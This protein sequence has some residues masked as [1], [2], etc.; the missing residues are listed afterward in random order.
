MRER[1]S[2]PDLDVY[3]DPA[4][5]HK[6]HRSFIQRWT[7]TRT[8][9]L[10][11]CQVLVVHPYTSRRAA[12]MFPVVKVQWHAVIAVALLPTT[13]TGTTQTDRELRKTRCLSVVSLPMETQACMCE[14]GDAGNF[15]PC[16]LSRNLWSL[17]D[18]LTMFPLVGL[19]GNLSTLHSKSSICK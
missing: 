15:S 19:I 13:G 8:T 12:R 4:V 18:H 7:T 3:G 6:T 1:S 11:H 2:L 10:C 14:Q 16:F 17:L 5:S 9:E